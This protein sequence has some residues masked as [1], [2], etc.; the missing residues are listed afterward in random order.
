M[1]PK[2]LTVSA[3]NLIYTFGL[4]MLQTKQKT[5]ICKFGLFTFNIFAIDFPFKPFRSVVYAFNKN[6]SLLGAMT[7]WHWNVFSYLKKL[8]ETTTRQNMR[9]YL[10]PSIRPIIRLLFP[11]PNSRRVDIVWH[12]LAAGRS[13]TR[14]V[15]NEQA[16]RDWKLFVLRCACTTLLSRYNAERIRHSKNHG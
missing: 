3:Y 15:Q 16:T 1:Y 12:S 9:I 11:V 2:G 13:R 4:K 6:N 5:K 10:L 14:T 8:Q 7:Q